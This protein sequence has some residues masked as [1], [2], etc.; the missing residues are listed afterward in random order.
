MGVEILIISS[1]VSIPPAMSTP[2]HLQLRLYHTSNASGYEITTDAYLD[3]SSW[4]LS[5]TATLATSCETNAYNLGEGTQG[6]I[7]LGRDQQCQLHRIR[8]VLYLL[9]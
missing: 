4:S 5:T 9:G 2:L 3:Y 7:G 6:I 8:C 1:V